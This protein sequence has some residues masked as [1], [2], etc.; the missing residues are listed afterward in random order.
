MSA[1]SPSVELGAQWPPLGIQAVNPFE[2]PLLNTVKSAINVAVWVKIPLYMPN[3][4]TNP[5]LISGGLVLLIISSL[6][7]QKKSK[8]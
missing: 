5:V 4:S 7:K 1:I 2:L 8:T 3:L 6:W